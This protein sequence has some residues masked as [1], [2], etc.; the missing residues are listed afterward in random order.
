M[1]HIGQ[2]RRVI[3]WDARTSG[4]LLYTGDL[5]LEGLLEGLILRSPYPHGGYGGRFSC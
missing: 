5:K 2:R 3:D 4:T 1:K